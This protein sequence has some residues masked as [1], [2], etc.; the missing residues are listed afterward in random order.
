MSA[1]GFGES[2]MRRYV[3]AGLLL[4]LLGQTSAAA[5]SSGPS[6]RPTRAT[7]V[8][9]NSA[10]PTHLPSGWATLMHQPRP[11]YERPAVASDPYVNLSRSRLASMH[12][13]AGVAE[14]VNY[15]SRPPRRRV[16]DP[17][18]MRKPSQLRTQGLF[19]ARPSLR[20]ESPNKPSG[21]AHASFSLAT[22]P[23]SSHSAQTLPWIK[24]HQGVSPQ[25]LA[26]TDTGAGIDRYWDYEERPIP[27]IGKA[28]VNVGTGNLVMQTT[29]FDIPERGLD[30]VMQRTYNSQSLHDAD[31]NDGSEPAIFG[32]GWTNTYDAHLVYQANGDI[33]VYDIDG[34]RCDYAPDTKNPGT[35]DPCPGEHA[36]LEPDPDVPCSY[37][38]IKKSGTA[39]WFYTPVPSG[40]FEAPGNIGRLYEIVGRNSN[41]TITLVYSFVPGQPQTSQNITE[42]DVDHS[43]RQY[44]RMGFAQV[45]GAGGPNELA[46][47]ALPDEGSVN[48]FYDARG[49]LQEV[50]RT[51]GNDA[52]SVLRETYGTQHP[53]QFACGPRATMSNQTDGACMHFDYD[54][55]V[56]LID[57]KVNGVLNF[58]P[59]DGFGKIQPG[60]IPTA[61]QNWYTADFVYGADA[62][63]PCGATNANTTTMCD[64]DGHST[65]WKI[66]SASQVTRTQLFTGPSTSLVTLQSWDAST[67]DLLSTTDA[68]GNETDY[69]YDTNGNTVEV[70]APQVQTSQGQIQPLSLYSYDGF[71]NIISY[72]DPV[73]NVGKTPPTQLTDSLCPT[74]SGSGNYVYQYTY[75]QYEPFGEL[76][77]IATPCYQSGCQDPGNY[78]TISYTSG[79]QG[80]TDYGLP[81]SVVGRAYTTQKDGTPRN[82]E[83]DFTYDSVGNLVTY[84]TGKNPTQGGAGKWTM[85]YTPDQMNRVQ[86]RTDPDG[87]TSQTCYEPDGSVAYTET[88]Y[89]Y[90][91]GLDGG[92]PCNLQ[93]I[94]PYAVSLTHDR[95]GSVLTETHH[96]GGQYESSPQP[97]PTP[98]LKGTAGTKKSFYDGEDRLVE[99]IQPQDGNRDL[100]TNAWITRYYYDL[101]QSD[102]AAT[103]SFQGKSANFAAYGN[104]YKTVE[105]LP[106]A[107]NDDLSWG[108][109]P[110]QPGPTPTPAAPLVNDTFADINAAAFDAADRPIA[111]YRIVSKSH[112]EQLATEALA[113][114]AD[115]NT[116]GLLASDCQLAVNECKTFSYDTM[117]R[118]TSDGFTL[119][120]NADPNTPNRQITYDPDGR[121]Q[122]ILQLAGVADNDTYTYDLDGRLIKV[123]K[124]T[125]RNITYTY[126]PDGK[127]KS[128]CGTLGSDAFDYSYAPDGTLQQL[129]YNLTGKNGGSYYGK[130][131]YT[132]TKAGRVTERDDYANGFGPM[133]TLRNYASGLLTQ[134]TFYCQSNCNGQSQPGSHTAMQYS[135]EGELL[136]Q[137]VMAPWSFPQTGGS[138]SPTQF[139]ETWYYNPRG[140]LTARFDHLGETDFRYANGVQVASFPKTQTGQQAETFAGAY[141]E[142]DAR[143]GAAIGAGYSFDSTKQGYHYATGQ[144][145]GITYDAD[146][147][148]VGSGY[149]GF[150]GTDNPSGCGS[151][152][153]L[154]SASRAYDIENHITSA[155]GSYLGGVFPSPS[156]QA[157]YVWGADGHPYQVG[158]TPYQG[159]YGAD[160]L[161][162]DGGSL[163]YTVTNSGSGGVDDIKLGTDAE[164]TP[165]DTGE[166]GVTF[167]DRGVD[168]SVAFCHNSSG[169]SGGWGD[170]DASVMQTRFFSGGP[171][172]PCGPPTAVTWGMKY[173]LEV[174]W[175][176]SYSGSVSGTGVGNGWTIGMMRG[177]GINDGVST[178]QGVRAYDPTA[179][180]WTA[181]D[182]YPGTIQDPMTQKAYMWNLNNAVK[183]SDVSG[184]DSLQVGFWRAVGWGG[185]AIWHV[186][187]ASEDDHGNIIRVYSYGPAGKFPNITLNKDF[188][189]SQAFTDYVS[190]HNLLTVAG[191]VCSGTCSWEAPFN[192]FYDAWPDDTILYGLGEIPG[193]NTSG[194]AMNQNFQYAGLSNW[195]P[196]GA[197]FPVGGWG[198]P[199]GWIGPSSSDDTS[200]DDDSM[201]A[202]N[203]DDKWGL[204]YSSEASELEEF[205]NEGETWIQ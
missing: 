70:L 88:P 118:I 148:N 81:T 204:S 203:G 82:P 156:Q 108:N 127:R 78:T 182:A 151:T 134:E 100:F 132:L 196:N 41:N 159:G 130:M 96:H 140:E 85:T 99:V 168:G 125:G 71:N 123:N 97:S 186:W 133:K 194:S 163:L 105:L 103:L 161:Y 14:R 10:L 195:L 35:W 167:Y 128:L 64:V 26:A 73:S 43:N 184:Y 165:N 183:Y 21:L 111:K 91:Q 55:N 124:P 9:V 69:G 178:I 149:G 191:S 141:A 48:Y 94:P 52:A 27:G 174:S 59:G 170:G 202:A 12:L 190:H 24:T 188:G 83:Q 51:D 121:T 162:W 17:R 146:G 15:P 31:G 66:N 79:P 95:D 60:P 101:S 98:D 45:G 116:Y 150:C 120:G 58:D 179:G 176:G 117:E 53:L 7:V 175:N 2:D 119:N 65:V 72:C 107:T 32:N 20:L 63:S 158:S 157:T 67:Y 40:C 93:S 153:V 75:P 131:V 39:Y 54:S 180:Q 115:G 1:A 129:N 166:S 87:D 192:A 13:R 56:N 44:I 143:M 68:R 92:G 25:I 74:S 147:R 38:W 109:A 80:G 144:T 193:S 61:F 197:P 90:S 11:R 126:Q 172:N 33:S 29:D 189:L 49:D 171:S 138:P 42:I 135:A 155:S 145:S 199:S 89:Q 113:Y 201:S 3:A 77:Y 76:T 152:Q 37:W 86:T 19:V 142:W 34:T 164:L 139:Y 106:S 137:F 160:D 84:V 154:E 177:D 47:I 28:M 6:N 104:L 198:E 200:G 23:P 110:E 46:S 205:S 57:W 22:R 4:T 122:Q 30:L 185:I 62:T 112:N 187:A 5:L 181:P 50:D 173:P 136:G 16:R 169:G 8:A 36:T 18:A 114:D 102:G